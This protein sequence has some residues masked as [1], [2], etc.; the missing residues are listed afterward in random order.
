M[1]YNGEN[2]VSFVWNGNAGNNSSIRVPFIIVYNPINSS[3]YIQVNG[4]YSIIYMY[5]TAI[6][7][8]G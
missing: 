8:G 6:Y 2:N 5:I 3:N 1:G 4:G 7:N